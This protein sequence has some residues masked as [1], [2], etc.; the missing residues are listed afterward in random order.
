MNRLAL[1]TEI[2]ERIQDEANAF[3]SETEINLWINL[4]IRAIWRAHFWPFRVKQGTVS[5]PAGTGSSLVPLPTDHGQTI[6][7]VHTANEYALE[8][9]P[10]RWLRAIYSPVGIGD[11]V[12]YTEGGLTH[13]TLTAAPIR[14]IRVFPAPSATTSL[15]VTYQA[16]PASLA[17]DTSYPNL[18][19]DFDQAII[20]WC[21]IKY[22]QKIDDYQAVAENK[23]MF[24]DELEAL[25]AVYGEWQY[26]RYPVIQPD[27]ES[28]SYPWR[29]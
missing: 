1:R 3:A 2:E 24:A 28:I 6:K 8:P 4:A 7:V 15:N 25:R 14:N 22:Y 16:L 11:P 13:T 9:R 18:P 20:E 26:E 17:A 27:V 23:E 10:E 12:F 5:C 21:L 19:E 29:T